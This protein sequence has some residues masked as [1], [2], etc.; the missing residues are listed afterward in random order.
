M[1]IV[2]CKDCKHRPVRDG[3]DIFKPDT[4][5][6]ICPY[7]CAGDSYYNRVPEDDWFCNFGEKKSD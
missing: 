4:F 5:D 2:K 1:D 6:T 7:L 3:A